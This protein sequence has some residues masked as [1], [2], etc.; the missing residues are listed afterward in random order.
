[1]QRL[2]IT[3]VLQWRCEIGIAKCNKYQKIVEKIQCDPENF[4][5]KAVASSDNKEILQELN[6]K[7]LK[8]KKPSPNPRPV[9]FLPLPPIGSLSSKSNVVVNECE[10]EQQEADEELLVDFL[11]RE[12]IKD[13]SDGEDEVILSLQLE[14]EENTIEQ[15]S[16]KKNEY[17]KEIEACKSSNSY[18]N[19]PGEYKNVYAKNAGFKEKRMHELNKKLHFIN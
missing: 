4:V 15:V 18:E 11:F 19:L 8:R 17:I 14:V 9:D 5:S 2:N 1:M 7:Q 3:N 6:E 16:F 12:I 10:N 13:D